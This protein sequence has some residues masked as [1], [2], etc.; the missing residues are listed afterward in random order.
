MMYAETAVVVTKERAAFTKKW[1]LRCPP[2]ATSFAEAGDELFTFLSFPMAQWRALRKT[3]ALHQSSGDGYRSRAKQ[4]MSGADAVATESKPP[5]EPSR[6][7]PRSCIARRG[8]GHCRAC[9]RGAS[10]ARVAAEVQDG[11]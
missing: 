2:V 11:R 9:L 7:L 3:N 6:S 1:R 10:E 5:R 4:P 8:L